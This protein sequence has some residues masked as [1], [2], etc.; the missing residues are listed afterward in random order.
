MFPLLL[1]LLL[2]IIVIIVDMMDRVSV[3]L[4]CGLIAIRNQHSMASEVY[5]SMHNVARLHRVG[6]T[7][8]NLQSHK[9]SISPYFVPTLHEKYVYNEMLLM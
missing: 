2:F 5:L 1:L 7:R 8:C 4:Y 9:T 3:L 6:G